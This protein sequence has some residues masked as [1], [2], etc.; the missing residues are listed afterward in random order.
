G[1]RKGDALVS[2]GPVKR[3]HAFAEAAHEEPDEQHHGTPSRVSGRVPK[4]IPE[5]RRRIH[6]LNPL[7]GIRGGFTRARRVLSAFQPDRC[8]LAKRFLIPW[9]A[10][11]PSAALACA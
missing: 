5:T 7:C 2:H 6:G 9:G 8:A 4:A 10:E 11:C 3:D 1:C